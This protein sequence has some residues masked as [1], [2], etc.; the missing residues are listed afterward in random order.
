MNTFKVF[1]LQKFLQNAITELGFEKPT[2]VQ[3]ES[4]PIIKSGSDVVGISQTGTGKTLAYLLPLLQELNFSQQTTPRILILVPT[5]ELVIQVVDT[6]KALTK[7]TTVRVYGAYGGVNINTQ[8][9]DVY[10]G[11]DIVVA[12][13]GRLYDLAICLAI[14]LKTIKKLVIDEVDVMLDLG[15]RHQ[16]KNLFELLPESRQ[17]IMFSATMTED[18]NDILKAFFKSPKRINISLSGEPLKNINQTCYSVK[19]FYTK[20]N[21]LKYLLLDKKNLS[22]IVIFLSNKKIADKLYDL[23]ES[24]YIGIIHSNKSQNA[25]IKTIELFDNGEYHALIATD[26]IA[27]GLDFSSVSHV[28][29]FDIPD[30]PENYIHR[31]GRSGRAKEKGNS[32]LFYT[33]KEKGAKL[34][35][36]KLMKLEIPELD[37]PENI[38][39]SNQLLPEEKESKNFKQSKNREQKRIAGPSFHEKSKKNNKENLGGKYKREIKTK[40]KKSRTRGDK[41]QNIR[42]KKK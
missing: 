21:L 19:N 33:E 5:R 42:K 23:I 22:K 37:F 6:I 28:I 18:V 40:Y 2:P 20:V 29:N 13:P 9:N 14:P 31:I 36:E 15:F 4:F 32:I 8:K 34:E 27:R 24:N 11:L 1:K 26:I 12:T 3:I 35:I 39:I 38:E 25:R 16:L 7:H 17:N 10:D 30:F 41:G